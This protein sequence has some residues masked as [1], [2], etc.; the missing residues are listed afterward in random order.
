MVA[1]DGQALSRGR[2]R[3]GAIRNPDGASFALLPPRASPAL[4]IRVERDAL[5][6][7]LEAEGVAN[8]PAQ[9]RGKQYF[10]V[11]LECGTVAGSQSALSDYDQSRRQCKCVRVRS[12]DLVQAAD[13][14]IAQ[15]GIAV[16]GLV[17][18]YVAILIFDYPKAYA[19]IECARSAS[20]RLGKYGLCEMR[21]GMPCFI[22]FFARRLYVAV[23]AI[24]AVVGNPFTRGRPH[25]LYARDTL[26][27]LSEHDSLTTGA[28]VHKS[29]CI[30]PIEQSRRR[31][32]ETGLQNSHQHFV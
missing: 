19:I 12:T 23:A 25:V 30:F 28:E 3:S 20:D 8:D 11:R 22:I 7:A 2:P 24:D 14:L 5:R 26:P 17:H 31:S 21:H 27:S 13:G 6:A 18:H 32:A 1:G 4:L 29:V 10:R 15:V 16:F 9:I